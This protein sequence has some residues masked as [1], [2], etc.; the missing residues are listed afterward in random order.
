VPVVLANP[1]ECA[2]LD[3]GIT[4]FIGHSISDCVEILD[5]LLASPDEVARIGTNAA[6]HARQTYTAE[7]SA[8]A[9]VSLWMSLI[10]QPKHPHDFHAVTGNTPLDWYLATQTVGGEETHLTDA[11]TQQSKGTLAHF[12]AA[13]PDDPCW[14]VL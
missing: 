11:S 14:N 13:F 12:R 5:R 10:A 1:A 6:R 4:G 3:H 7:R 2:I 8:Q 9:F